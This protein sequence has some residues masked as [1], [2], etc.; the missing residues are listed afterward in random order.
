MMYSDFLAASSKSSKQQLLVSILQRNIKDGCTLL[1][2]QSEVSTTPTGGETGS[3][4]GDM[5]DE[6]GCSDSDLA[7]VR[8]YCVEQYLLQD[9]VKTPYLNIND[10]VSS[11]CINKDGICNWVGRHFQEAERSVFVD[12]TTNCASS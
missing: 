11:E 8:A 12:S 9:I 4:S 1:K 10:A 7:A 6:G 3:G 5:V 2:Q